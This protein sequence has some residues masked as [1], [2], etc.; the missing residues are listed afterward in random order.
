MKRHKVVKEA[1]E[2]PRKVEEAKMVPRRSYP[3][4]LPYTFFSFFSA[5]NGRIETWSRYH[6]GFP[7]GEVDAAAAAPATGLAIHPI[8]EYVVTIRDMTLQIWE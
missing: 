2:E 8:D 7:I 4:F 3:P 5:R 6:L 1:T